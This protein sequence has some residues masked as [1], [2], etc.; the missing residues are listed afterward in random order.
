M[1]L[2][3][4]EI[5]RKI[6]DFRELGFPDYVPRE[7]RVHLVKN[8]VS[9]IIGGRRAGKSFRALQAAAE[10]IKEGKV[11]SIRAVCPL[12][13]DNPILSEMNARELKGI[14]A[15]FLKV[16][17]EFDLKSPLVFLFDEIH[18]I[19]GWEEAV[20]DIARNPHWKVIV[21]GSS[22][23]LLRDEIATELRGKAISSSVFPL[24]FR[25]FL[26]F[27]GCA[28]DIR[29]TKGEAE[30]RRY[31]DEYLKWGAYPAIA[32]LE[33]YSR[34]ALL[35]EYFDTMILKDIIQRYDV[36]KPRVCTQLLSY[37]L[38]NI[39][40]PATLQSAYAYIK[41]NGFST[42]RD[43][44][45]DYTNWAMDSWLLFMVPLFSRSHK[46]QE[47]NHKKVY[48]ID[49][50][51]AVQNSAVWDGSYSRALENL[52]FLHLVRGFPRVHFYLTKP[53]RQ[54]V[55]FIALNTNGRPELSVQACVG[56]DREETLERELEPLVAAAKYLG[57]RSNVIVTLNQEKSY[58]RE[59]VSVK[60]VPAWKWLLTGQ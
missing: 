57:T 52:V 55:D 35:R 45:R 33:E 21:T 46:E 10:L 19:P 15:I 20:I 39:S 37:L 41:G 60:V 18:K 4:P 1:S 54:E 14:P 43:A 38:S 12:D 7:G 56:I 49:W 53:K 51:L 2:W 16:S 11:P 42:S 17:P 8:A 26:K 40:K 6:G 30:A 44:I 36:G 5:Q 22:S 34:A 13:F 23:K 58:R 9:T 59:G 31:F 3:E 24:S 25:E 28:H 48:C 29:S 32:N 27:K 50:G 47:R